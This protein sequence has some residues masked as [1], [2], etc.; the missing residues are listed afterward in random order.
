MPRGKAPR[1]TP[2]ALAGLCSFAA[3]TTTQGGRNAIREC[4]HARGLVRS[5]LWDLHVRSGSKP[6]SD[7]SPT[8]HAPCNH[9][10][11]RRTAITPS[12]RGL[13]STTV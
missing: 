4:G 3:C 13:P 8:S 2:R 6:A 7:G 11:G 9:E 12:T 10:S 5:G 1:K